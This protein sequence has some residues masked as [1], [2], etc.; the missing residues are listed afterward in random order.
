MG[1]SGCESME[2]VGGEKKYSLKVVLEKGGRCRL[3]FA[4]VG[5]KMR[6]AAWIGERSWV[7]LHMRFAHGQLVS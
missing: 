3:L 4:I 2:D 5:S 7:G 6:V 1:E